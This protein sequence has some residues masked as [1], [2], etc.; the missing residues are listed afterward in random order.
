MNRFSSIIHCCILL[1]LNL[2]ISESPVPSLAWRSYRFLLAAG[3]ILPRRASPRPTHPPPPTALI[4]STSL[5][6]LQIKLC[7]LHTRLRHYLFTISQITKI[8]AHQHISC[9]RGDHSGT[10]LDHSALTQSA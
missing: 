7:V 2:R 8:R 3:L 10:T 1:V 6:L 9:G 5:L 4:F